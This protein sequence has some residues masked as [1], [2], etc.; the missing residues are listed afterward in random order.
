V[1]LSDDAH[2]DGYALLQRGAGEIDLHDH[3][4]TPPT[5]VVLTAAAFFLLTFLR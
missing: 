4:L 3:K 1:A 2:G 5:N